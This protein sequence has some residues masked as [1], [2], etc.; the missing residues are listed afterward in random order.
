MEGLGRPSGGLEFEGVPAGVRCGQHMLLGVLARPKTVATPE[1]PTSSL[2]TPRLELL[3]VHHTTPSCSSLLL[4]LLDN[5]PFTLSSCR[6]RQR[7]VEIKT[8]EIGVYVPE[9][10]KRKGSPREAVAK[11]VF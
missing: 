9:C 4:L 2:S 1:F 6:R 8:K 3:Y 11:A 7:S 5:V 10:L